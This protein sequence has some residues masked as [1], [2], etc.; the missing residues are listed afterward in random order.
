M[1]YVIQTKITDPVKRKAFLEQHDC[2]NTDLE[3]FIGHVDS[4]SEYASVREDP[5][6]GVFIL[7]Q[8]VFLRMQDEFFHVR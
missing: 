3:L 5:R 8:N 7:R 1:V 2:A 6:L 4:S